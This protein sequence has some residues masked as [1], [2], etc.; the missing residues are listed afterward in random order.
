MGRDDLKVRTGTFVTMKEDVLFS[1]NV[2]SC[3]VYFRERW[4]RFPSGFPLK[5]IAMDF[6]E[7]KRQ[8]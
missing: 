2:Q 3:D 4:H 5:P 8:V 6:V 7:R 1:V